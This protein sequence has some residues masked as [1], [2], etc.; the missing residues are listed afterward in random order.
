MSDTAEPARSAQLAALDGALCAL[1]GGALVD[2]NHAWMRVL[3]EDRL[4]AA[5]QAFTVRMAV[6][7]T[8]DAEQ[9]RAVNHAIESAIGQLEILIRMQVREMLTERGYQRP[10]VG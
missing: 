3:T 10:D 5:A 8:L 7:D 6:L 1:P 9:R 2:V 4:D